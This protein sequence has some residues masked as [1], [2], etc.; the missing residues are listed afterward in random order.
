MGKG[1][2]LTWLKCLA[3]CFHINSHGFI[4]MLRRRF[5]YLN[6]TDEK[7]EAIRVEVAHDPVS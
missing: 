5:N 3:R 2:E 1:T 7:S 6:F 4:T